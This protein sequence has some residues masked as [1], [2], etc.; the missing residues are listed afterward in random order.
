[1]LIFILLIFQLNAS[2]NIVFKNRL[3]KYTSSVNQYGLPTNILIYC[4]FIGHIMYFFYRKR[5][6]EYVRLHNLYS[7]YMYHK[8]MR[9]YVQSVDDIH[10]KEYTRLNRYFTVRKLQNGKTRGIFR[11]NK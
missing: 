3:D 7:E 10:Y 4:V 9:D 2:I 6:K 11:F 8:N 5:I 1:M